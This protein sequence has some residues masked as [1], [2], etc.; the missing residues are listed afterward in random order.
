MTDSPLSIALSRLDLIQVGNALGVELKKGLQSRPGEKEAKPSFSVFEG[1]GGLAWKDH[2]TGDGG[3]VWG[4]VQLLRP[5]WS[6]SDVARFLIETAGLDPNADGMNRR[7]RRE[8]MLKKRMK[9]AHEF[10]REKPFD[11]PSLP[12]MEPMAPHVRDRYRQGW[13][14]L[15][16]DEKRR[17]DLAGQRDWPVEWVEDLRVRGLLSDP[18][19]PWHEPGDRGAQ[20]GFAFLVQLP[21]VDARG[22]VQDLVSVGYHQRFRTKEGRSWLF[23][24]HKPQRPA[25]SELDR[26]LV[27]SAQVVAPLPFVMGDPDASIWVILEGQWDAATFW[28]VWQAQANPPS[29][30]VVGV[31][32]VNG[33]Q[34]FLS[35]WG[36]V[37][38]RV[39]PKV[40]CITDNDDAGCRW[41][42]PDP[43]KKDFEQM[44]F[45]Q[46]LQRW[47]G[48]VSHSQIPR[49]CGKDF[50]DYFSNHG[51]PQEAADHVIS[52]I[53][54]AFPVL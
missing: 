25:R 2:A 13:V 46:Q 4:L 21:K 20:R 3:G 18:V 35:A 6:K 34:V 15:G 12:A 50:N 45:V 33:N 42:K 54:Q 31:R 48:A 27:S 8:D 37:M 53:K 36:R 47:G 44:T 14:G 41:S 5:D 22:R 52:N 38:R 30:F 10:F 9:T 51:T 29:V 32:G 1:K 26:A 23:V 7:Q 28:Y 39:C 24:P 40:W 16:A 17:Q 43:N 49:E 19:L 11:L